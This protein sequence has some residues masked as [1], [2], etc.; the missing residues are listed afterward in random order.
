MKAYYSNHSR[1]LLLYVAVHVHLRGRNR[2][3]G[4][5]AIVDSLDSQMSSDNKCSLDIC[6][7]KKQNKGM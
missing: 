2:H 1:L 4:G 6:F 5:A 7:S 3:F